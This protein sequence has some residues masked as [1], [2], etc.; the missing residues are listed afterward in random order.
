LI[1]TVKSEPGLIFD[2]RRFSVHDGPGIRTTVFFKGCPLSCWWCHNPES[3]EFRPE[4]ASRRI[5][6]GNKSLEI[7]ETA[8][9]WM[10]VGEVM[11]QLACDTAFYEES[12]G[13]ITFSGG[14]PLLQPGFLA[15][16]LGECRKAGFHTAIDTSGYAEPDV[17]ARVASLADLVLYDL[18]LMEED[19]HLNYTGVSNR[20]ILRNLEELAATGKEVIL[21]F[22]VIPGITDTA[23]NVRLMKEFIMTRLF[24]AIR[25]ISLLPYH[26][27]AREKY[28]RFCKDNLLAGLPSL[29]ANDL[30]PLKA[31]FGE[32]GMEVHIGG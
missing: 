14:E 19:E 12:S 11:K 4:S 23:E 2:I 16:L 22:P 10:T 1:F 20:M 3:R 27:M 24:P 26:A 30:A 5:R 13:G 28:R 31:A 21:R 8:G 25:K 15:G 29:E 7:D 6:A 17:M 32:I 9:K 18:K